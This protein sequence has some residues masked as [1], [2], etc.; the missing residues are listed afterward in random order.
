[1]GKT[2]VIALVLIPNLAVAQSGVPNSAGLPNSAPT[3]SASPRD[4]QLDTVPPH[5]A[6]PIPLCSPPFHVDQHV[7][8]STIVSFKIAKDGTV[9]DIA[10]QRS[11]GA[12]AVDEA[13]KSCVA[14][15]IYKPA[16][17][18]GQPV[19]FPTAAQFEWK[20]AL[21]SEMPPSDPSLAARVISFPVRKDRHDS[22]ELWHAAKAVL[23][24]FYVEPDGS[25]K[26]VTIL[27]PSGDAAID[28]D[29]IDCVSGRAYKPA[30]RDGQPIE[31]RLTARLY[32]ATRFYSV[33]EDVP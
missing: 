20:P 10:V 22:C 28:K 30:M 29:A 1:M 11:S 24:S 8:G 32:S 17:R 6:G 31:I 2:L 13:A 16:I 9:E 21:R 7:T 19:E 4:L 18:N 12:V 5:V 27:Q 15:R 3:A 25:V 14:G 23:L 26:N 33:S